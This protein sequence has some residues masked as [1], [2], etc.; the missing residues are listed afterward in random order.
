MCPSFTVMERTHALY[1]ESFV[2]CLHQGRGVELFKNRLTLT[3]ELKC[4]VGISGTLF[5][6]GSSL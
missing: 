4:N 3:W 6:T 2:E 1:L 5:Q